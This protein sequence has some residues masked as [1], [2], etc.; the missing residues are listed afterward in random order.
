MAGCSPLAIVA[1]R[2][3]VVVEFTRS[4]ET[5]IGSDGRGT[6]MRWSNRNAAR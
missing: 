2:S 6:L 4:L 3:S 1:K 5:D